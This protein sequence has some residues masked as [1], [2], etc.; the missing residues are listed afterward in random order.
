MLHSKRADF[1]QHL[2]VVLRKKA[3][4]DLRKD[5]AFGPSHHATNESKQ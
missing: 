2:S 1:G 3:G 5:R 4:Q